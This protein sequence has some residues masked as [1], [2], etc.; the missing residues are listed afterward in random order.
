MP[1]AVLWM[2]SNYVS[3]QSILK[4]LLDASRVRHCEMRED[5]IWRIWGLLDTKV[6]QLLMEFWD[7]SHPIPLSPVVRGKPRTCGFRSGA[8]KMTTD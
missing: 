6:Q 4:E 5:H 3:I 7:S 1:L 2:D 8:Y